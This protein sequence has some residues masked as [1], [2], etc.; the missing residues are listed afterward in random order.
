MQLNFNA[1]P[2]EEH[3]RVEHKG[4]EDA[5]NGQKLPDEGTKS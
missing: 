1:P 5:A 3:K 4:D 2:T